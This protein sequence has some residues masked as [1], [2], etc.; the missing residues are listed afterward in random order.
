MAGP[1]RK[2]VSKPKNLRATLSRLLHYL[3]AYRAQLALVV[4]CIVISAG[5]SVT[6]TYFLKPLINNYIL[7]LVGR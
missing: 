5:A 2:A 3:G 4:V 1:M 6:G 7:P